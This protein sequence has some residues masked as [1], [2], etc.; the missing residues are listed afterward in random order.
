MST[1]IKIIKSNQAHILELVGT[2]HEVEN[3][4]WENVSKNETKPN[5][6]FLR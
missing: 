3:F 2:M 1:H 6:E 5:G 4:H